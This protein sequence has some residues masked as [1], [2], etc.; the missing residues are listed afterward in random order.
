MDASTDPWNRLRSV[1][2]ALR[3]AGAGA[4]TLDPSRARANDLH[5]IGVALLAPDEPPAVAG[6]FA[7]ALGVIAEAL[8]AHFPDN[9]FADLDHLAAVLL[10]TARGVDGPARAAD[11]RSR[12]VA[13]FAAFGCRSPIRFRYGHDF[14]YGFDWERW[15]SR[16]PG[17]RSGVGPFDDAF[18]A[19]MRDRG[20]EITRAIAI[21][22]RSHPVLAPGVWR[23]PFPFSRE[24]EHEARLLRDLAAR[25]AV[26]VRAWR[27]DTPPD[28]RVDAS[29]LRLE[30]ARA[31]DIPASGIS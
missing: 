28:W 13:L 5:T 8:H 10:R 3:V 20:R 4:E 7:D 22:D 25:E 11:L 18:L 1:D 27:A 30:R 12:I 31:L 19:H 16:E 14:L 15:V 2:S 9:V 26:P 29:R 24:P 6:A 17:A 23:N 21:G